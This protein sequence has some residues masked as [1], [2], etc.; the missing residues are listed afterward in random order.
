MTLASQRVPENQRKL[1]HAQGG[2]RIFLTFNLKRLRHSSFTGKS[3]SSDTFVLHFLKLY[4][5]LEGF[6]EKLL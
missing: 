1:W 5:S 2:E 4:T 6:S 3:I